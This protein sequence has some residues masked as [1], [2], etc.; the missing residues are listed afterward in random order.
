MKK[1]FNTKKLTL[2]SA[3][4]GIKGGNKIYMNN[5]YDLHL[6]TNNIYNF[7]KLICDCPVCIK[8]NNEFINFINN[9]SN[10]SQGVTLFYLHN[11]WKYIEYMKFVEQISNDKILME[12]IIVNELGKKGEDLIDFII[13]AKEK[14]IEE[15]Y[16][17]YKKYFIGFEVIYNQKNIKNNSMLNYF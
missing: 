14:G 10:F 8:L 9:N 12:Q 17:K 2:D 1:L 16:K 11:L 5:F 6:K 3:S 7:N 15:A 4:Y 13:I